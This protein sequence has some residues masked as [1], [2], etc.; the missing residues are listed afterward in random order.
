MGEGVREQDAPGPHAAAG[1]VELHQQDVPSSWR[2]LQQAL[3]QEMMSL[4]QNFAVSMDYMV[5]DRA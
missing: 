3:S 1:Q 5:K 4:V 2:I